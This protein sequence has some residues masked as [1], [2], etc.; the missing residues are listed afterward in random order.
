[1]ISWQAAP[2]RT[3]PSYFIDVGYEIGQ[4]Q[5][6]CIFWARF[7]SVSLFLKPVYGLFK[8]RQTNSLNICRIAF[9]YVYIYFLKRMQLGK[10]ALITLTS[11]QYFLL[12]EK[13]EENGRN[14]KKILTKG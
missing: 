10:N 8:I 7:G 1:M 5:C 9:K 14:I 3:L 2:V 13:L 6:V 11:S 12:I 4:G